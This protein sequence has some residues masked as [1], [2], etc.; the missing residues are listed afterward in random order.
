MTVSN[1]P[2]ELR[3]L[4]YHSLIKRWSYCGV[5]VLSYY[6]DIVLLQLLD[7]QLRDALLVLLM[8]LGEYW[9]TTVGNPVDLL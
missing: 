6:C 9:K 7:C 1:C 4:F 3:V 5:T 8:Q 2:I